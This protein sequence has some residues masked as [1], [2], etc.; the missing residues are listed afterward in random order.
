MRQYKNYYYGETNY[1]VKNRV[2]FNVYFL[3]RSEVGAYSVKIQVKLEV[4]GEWVWR[5][6]IWDGATSILTRVIQ[7]S[8]I[9]F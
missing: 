8:A 6:L 1:C 2:C 7:F 5:F 9:L 3:V 4:D